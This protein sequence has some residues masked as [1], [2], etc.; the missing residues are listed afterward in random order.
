ME[1]QLEELL[2]T[3]L[4]SCRYVVLHL[5]GY[6]KKGWLIIALFFLFLFLFKFLSATVAFDCISNTL[7]KCLA[8]R[9][10]MYFYPKR[11]S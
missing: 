9:V 6:G 11:D 1:Q 10:M 8:S 2:D 5:M 7:W 3:V 4:S